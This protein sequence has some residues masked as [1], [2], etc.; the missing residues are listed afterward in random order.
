LA[1]SDFKLEGDI[2][3]L[4]APTRSDAR[5]LLTLRVRNERFFAPFE[6]AREADF[7]TLDAQ[8]RVLAGDLEAWRTGQAY[9]FVIVERRS[10]RM[11]GW[12]RLSNVARG[13]WQNATL[14]YAVD[15][16]V[17]GRG[18]ATEAVGLV[19]RFAFEHA[20]LHRVQA[21]VMPRNVASARVLAKNGFR[22]EGRSL[23]YLCLAGAWEDHD[24]YAITREDVRS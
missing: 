15:E 3:A 9:A 21:A 12:V 11:L 20:G 7:L 18:V 14:G 13:V 1:R 2:V 5:E 22:A 17:N 24:I 19:V 4:R 6:P 10:E 8:E 16:S 23:R